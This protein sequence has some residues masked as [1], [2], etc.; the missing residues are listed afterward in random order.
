MTQEEKQKISALVIHTMQIERVLC[1]EMN[2]DFV[3]AD[4]LSEV[5]DLLKKEK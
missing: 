4:E 3:I 2:C 5:I 1:E